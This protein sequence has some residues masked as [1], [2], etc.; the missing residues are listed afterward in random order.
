MLKRLFSDDECKQFALGDLHRGKGVDFP[1]IKI[2]KATAVVFNRQA[3]PVAHKFNVA[4][5]GFGAD[6]QVGREAGGVGVFA[7]LERLVDA[8]HPL[9]RRTR[10]GL[11]DRVRPGRHR[12]RHRAPATRGGTRH[13]RVRPGRSPRRGRRLPSVSYQK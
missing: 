8:E 3:E 12:E 13:A 4:M 2:A 6:F 5:N 9:Q 7:G 11:G 10:E 1:G